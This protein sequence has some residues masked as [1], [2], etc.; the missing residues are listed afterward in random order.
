MEQVKLWVSPSLEEVMMRI[1]EVKREM[2]NEL[3]ELRLVIDSKA[4]V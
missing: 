4:T 1:E 3:S 2:V